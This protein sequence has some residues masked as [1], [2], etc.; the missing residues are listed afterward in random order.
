MD[1]KTTLPLAAVAALHEG[2]K[3]EAIKLVRAELGVDL[4]EAKERVEQCL[5]TEPSVQ[6]RFAEMQ[7][8]STGS[9]GWLLIAAICAAG[10]LAY[11][12]RSFG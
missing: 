9:G 12:W 1:Q 8:Q 2:R 7:G 4:K 6:A 10:V 11:L 5:R 3:I